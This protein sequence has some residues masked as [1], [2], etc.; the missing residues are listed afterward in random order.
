MQP[1]GG[2]AE[3]PAGK[4]GSASPPAAAEGRDDSV[5]G[6]PSAVCQEK[7]PTEASC[8]TPGPETLSGL[9]LPVEEAAG[10][11][12]PR[13]VEYSPGPMVLGLLIA[14]KGMDCMAGIHT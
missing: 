7:A 5:E 3:I 12:E 14:G 4:S 11:Q 13:A 1:E 8:P 6:V 9:L 10:S 2:P